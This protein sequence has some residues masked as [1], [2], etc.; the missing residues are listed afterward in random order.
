[1]GHAKRKSVEELT[2]VVED[3]AK[4]L[5]DSVVEA[6]IAHPG[7][8]VSALAVA[9]NAL[10]GRGP[11]DEAAPAEG[12]TDKPPIEAIGSEPDPPV[13]TAEA[14]RR[15]LAL[16]RPGKREKLL[17]SDELAALAGL[18]S[19]QTV[20]N[21]LKKGRLI[22]W[23]SAKRGYVFPAVQLDNRRRPLPGLARIIPLFDDGYSAWL[24]LT[25][26]SPA[27]SGA[28]PLSRLHKG[29]IDEVEAAAIGYGH[30]DF[31]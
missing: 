1:M 19:R 25:T 18:K 4:D 9:G 2:S 10:V 13:D 7:A 21:W 20:H 5:S 23:E 3:A 31:A 16:T 6:L 28:T 30:G 17:T 24:W 12:T 29:C 22:G 26:P 27:L 14:E 8:V 11:V 15:L